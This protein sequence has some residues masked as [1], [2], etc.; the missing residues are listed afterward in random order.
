VRVPLTNLAV[1]LKLAGQVPPVVPDNAFDS[2]NYLQNGT[3]TI[4]ALGFYA[5]A[6]YALTDKFKITAGG[7]FSHEKR[8]GV[9]TF[10]FLG[11]VNTDKAK[12]GTP[13]PR[14]R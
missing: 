13:S 6:T 10:D 14:S 4:D 12:A 1:L 7:R 11:S 8:K 3:V 5:Q 9:G 2:F